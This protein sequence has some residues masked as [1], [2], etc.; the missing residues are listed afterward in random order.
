MGLGD[1]ETVVLDFSEQRQREY[2][3]AMGVK[4]S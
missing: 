4:G 1:A 2:H 3:Q